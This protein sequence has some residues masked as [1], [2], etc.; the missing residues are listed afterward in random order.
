MNNRTLRACWMVMAAALIFVSSSRAQTSCS[1]GYSETSSWSGGFNGGITIY[2]TGTTTIPT[3]SLGFAFAN[4][5]IVSNSWNS[6]YSQNGTNVTLT[7]GQY[8]GNIAPGG[9]VNSVGFTASWNNTTN[10]I[11]TAFTLN[12]VACSFAPTA[13]TFTVSGSS[14]V[15]IAQGGG[16]GEWISVNG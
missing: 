8:A 1:V 10:A 16:G 9:S 6:T 14:S 15:S 5:Q 11:P 12:G 4:G 3:W 2:N 13:G 7:N